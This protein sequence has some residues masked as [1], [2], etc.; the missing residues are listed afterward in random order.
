MACPPVGGDS[1]LAAFPPGG[2]G[3]RIS[4]RDSR[5]SPP[6]LGPVAG[7]AGVQVEHHGSQG[8]ATLPSGHR[9]G[10]AGERHGHRLSGAIGQAGQFGGKDRRPGPVDPAREQRGHDQRQPGQVPGQAK[11]QIRGPARQH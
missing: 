5:A 3:A 6:G 4:C 9:A 7:S 1:R 10:Q 8:S 11:Q 2:A